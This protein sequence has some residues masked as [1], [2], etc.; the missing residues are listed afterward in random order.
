M[1]KTLTWVLGNSEIPC[2]STVDHEV[3]MINRPYLTGLMQDLSSRAPTW[4][5]NRNSYCAGLR[6]AQT[7]LHRTP[8]APYPIP[9]PVL[10]LRSAP[11]QTV[12][13]T[14]KE[15][16]DRKSCAH[17]SK[18]HRRTPP[19]APK[20][21][22]QTTKSLV[23]ALLTPPEDTESIS[24]SNA[25]GGVVYTSPGFEPSQ[26]L[27]GAGFEPSQVLSGARCWSP[28]LAPSARYAG[29]QTNDAM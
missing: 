27:S 5:S 20:R 21:V 17:P 7:A 3:F 19:Q 24:R 10:R 23:E 22:L 1:S 25:V 12:K 6:G 18:K 8:G 14:V 13:L 15:P 29:G 9:D 26:V 11:G 4:L 16:F 28:V 2:Q